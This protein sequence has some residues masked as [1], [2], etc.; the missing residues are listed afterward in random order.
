MKGWQGPT[1]GVAAIALAAAGS[2]LPDVTVEGG[3]Q[4][5]PC[6]DGVVDLAAGEECDPG[7][8]AGEAGVVGCTG[9]CRVSCAGVIDPTSRHCY[10]AGPPTARLQ[11]GRDGCGGQRAHLV[12]FASVDELAFVDRRV[13]GDSGAALEWVNLD[14]VDVDGAAEWHTDT[15]AAGWSGACPGCF[16]KA[17]PEAG[18]FPNS[19]GGLGG[20]CVLWA[21]AYPY[22]WLSIPCD[23]GAFA[24]LATVCEREVVGALSRPCDGG[25]CLAVPTTAAD[26][27]YLYAAT[28]RAWSDAASAC[29]AIAGP[30]GP[31]R[32]FVP[33]SAEEREEVTRAVAAKGASFWIGLSRAG[34]AWTWADGKALTS[35]VYPLPWGD[36]APEATGTAAWVAADPNRYDVG[37]AHAG[38]AATARPF[39]CAFDLR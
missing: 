4:A 17:P 9:D 15:T 22:S 28:P 16:A 10:F 32:L 35:L 19:D 30:T 14:R 2:C 12:T 38:D 18:A 27:T 37:L 34:G 7:P 3:A 23:V 31:G 1:L 21:R 13:L 33:R 36:Q 39:V 20:A 5:R 11:A 26:R 24:Q 8:D 25:A 6:G 29:G